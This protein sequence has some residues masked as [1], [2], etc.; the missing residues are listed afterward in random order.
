MLDCGW[1]VAGITAD[2]E[3]LN[4]EGLTLE[5]FGATAIED[6][7]STPAGND[8][9]KITKVKGKKAD[10]TVSVVLFVLAGVFLLAGAATFIVLNVK[11]GGRK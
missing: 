2:E 4:A 8:I 1:Q 11:K 6:E 5:Q 3:L 9:T 10:N 7:E